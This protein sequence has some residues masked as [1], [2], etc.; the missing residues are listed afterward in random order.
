M[1]TPGEEAPG[2]WSG[3]KAI[4]ADAL[5]LPA[6]ERAAFAE[7]ACGEDPVLRREVFSML[8]FSGA[9]DDPATASPPPAV[10]EDL[11]ERAGQTVG[12]WRITREIGR[13]GMGAVYLAE[14]ADRVFE[15]QVAVK[16][17][18]RGT[19]TD[20]V[21]RRFRTERQILARL[22]HP[23]IARLL[24]GGTTPD[25]L[26][27][28]V[29][30]YVDGARIT[31]WC[32]ARRLGFR[33]R[34]ELFLKVCEAVH[35]AHRNLVVHRDLKP[36]NL[37]VTAEGEPKLLD[38]GI[39]KLLGGEE[40]EESLTVEGRQLLTPGYASP[41]QVRGEPVTTASDVYSLGALLHELLAGRPPHR[42]GAPAELRRAIAEEDP[43]RASA[44]AAAP[45]ARRALRGDLDNILRQA[46]AR[47]PARRYS[48]VTAFADDLR[49]HLER[50]PVRAR[51]PTLGYRA[52][53]FVRRNK[54]A[55]A[56]GALLLV[57]LAGGVAATL[58]QKGRA[59]R[60]FEDVRRLARA[61]IFDYHDAIAALPGSTPVREK[62]VKDALTY[63]D[64]L[65]R[66]A[67]SDPGLKGEL[68]AAYTKIGV[69]QGNSY[70]ANLGDTTGALRSA[71]AALALREELLAAAPAA[72]PCRV[73]VADALVGLG[74]IQ[75]A[76]GELRAA[77]ASYERAL[78]L[79]PQ[80]PS[81]RLQVLALAENHA[82]LSDLLGLDGYTNLG[83]TAGALAHL[84]AARVLVEPLTQAPDADAKAHDRFVEILFSE[85]MMARSAGDAALCLAQA[86]R[87]VELARPFAEANRNEQGA[88]A[89]YQ[90]ALS[91]LGYALMEDAQWTEAVALLRAA[92]VD[93]ERMA[94]GD[95]K[96]TQY[97]I[98]LSISCNALGRSLTA[99]GD[100][101]AAEVLHRRA[102]ALSDEALG[103]D[104]NSED[105]QSAVSFSLQCLGQALV[106][107]GKGEA[108]SEVLARALAL[109]ER[110]VQRDPA[111]ARAKEDVWTIQGDLGAARSLAGDHSG[112]VSAFRAAV[113]EAEA[114]ARQDPS[115]ALK[116]A[117]CG[118]LHL[119]FG[120]ACQRHA[121]AGGGAEA[122]AVALEQLGCAQA[123][124]RELRERNALAPRWR[125]RAEETDH[126]LA[127]LDVQ[128]VPGG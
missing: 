70:Y 91:L 105:Y 15:K 127:T 12:A 102:L 57:T 43:A 67:G 26:P 23:N 125:P 6:A 64:A 97:R 34:I 88:H 101:A 13:G 77:R 48:D 93:D 87:A 111:N 113:P 50:R 3:V 36:G 108:A 66:D 85:T 73:D 33:A 126:A 71:Q 90:K 45:E 49:R 68:A 122:A 121:R 29:L 114:Q 116:R 62:I 75:Y 92:L 35:F 47:Q 79:R 55:V 95:P 44:V 51:R 24:D 60:R 76:R 104:P 17:L 78:A 89:V 123:I 109:R 120:Q 74:D 82:R 128:A 38:F 30:E 59:E 53:R 21:L 94:A 18:K 14:R 4:V 103:A 100:A 54:L 52:S 63:L 119:D 39:A 69:V 56:G 20:E 61:V 84:R 58:V 37:L 65:R 8:A 2:H 27:F 106:A 80:P 32:D 99:V 16:I 72:P 5:E 22:E 98:N 28:F 118:K 9:D 31:D 83:D 112:A 110:A 19:D 11:A 86:R 10:A 46:L 115:N 40:G 124:W 117:R 96:N 42:F 7:R 81:G 1:N 25:G 41:E 107:Q